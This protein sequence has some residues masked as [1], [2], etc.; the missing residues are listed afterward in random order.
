MGAAVQCEH[1]ED[2]CVYLGLLVSCGFILQIT[3]DSNLVSLKL[4]SLHG[5]PQLNDGFGLR[6]HTVK[7]SSN[8][9]MIILLP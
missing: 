6:D 9:C 8:S 1:K 7:C 5:L 4:T 3:F 2:G